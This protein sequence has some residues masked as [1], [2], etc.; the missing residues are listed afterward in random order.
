VFVDHRIQVQ[1]DMGKINSQPD[2]YTLIQFDSTAQL[3]FENK[4]LS[5]SH[6]LVP[7]VSSICPVGKTAYLSALDLLHKNNLIKG[8]ADKRYEIIFLSDGEDSGNKGSV[9]KLIEQIEQSAKYVTLHTVY[10]GSNNAGKGLLKEMATA[11]GGSF[12][13]ASDL[14]SLLMAFQ[15]LAGKVN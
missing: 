5:S 1:N 9:M 7:L 15:F 13:I 11:G 12:N 8:A 10:L 2:S 14:K 4:Q 6:D 3:V